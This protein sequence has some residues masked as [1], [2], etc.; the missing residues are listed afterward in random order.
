VKTGVAT[1][2]QVRIYYRDVGTGGETLILLHGYPETGEAF[3]PAIASLGARYRLII[4]DLRGFGRSQRPAG[5][6]DTKTVASDIKLLADQLGIR[7][8]HLVGYDIGARVAYAYALQYPRNLRSLTLAE[9]FIEGLSG[10]AQVR[11]VAPMVPRLKHFAEYADADG[12]ERRHLGKEDE[13]ILSFMNSRTKARTF[14]SGDVTDYVAA[15]RRDRGM[16][17]A[18]KYF[19]AFDQDADYVAGADLSQTVGL[20]VLTIGCAAGSADMLERQIRQAGFTNIKPVLIA[21]C[22]HWILE[23]TPAET[24]RAIGDFVAGASN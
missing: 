15:F 16:W 3:A 12:A 20:P 18:F 8:A 19:Q 11:L 14:T 7:R 21:G 5:G 24:V 22:S 4:P 13:L 6:Y 1:V 10:T 9:S 17:A 23:E 2:N